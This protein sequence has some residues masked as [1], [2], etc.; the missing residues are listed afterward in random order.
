MRTGL[1]AAAFVR[2]HCGV[3]PVVR[4]VVRALAPTDL[5]R[6]FR[7]LE[8]AFGH[9]PQDEDVPV[10]LALVDP[11][12][13]YG[14]YAGDEL[15]GTAGSFAFPMTVPGGRLDVAG[16]TWVGV[17]PTARRQ[18]VLR[19]FMTGQLADLHAAGTAVAA[20]WASE[21]AIYPRYGY[22][23]AAWHHA[24]SIPRGA[25]FHRQVEPGGLRHV[26]PSAALLGPVYDAVAART[27]G[28][29]ARDD[30]WWALRLHD[31]EHARAGA[32]A[33]QCVVTDGGYALYAVAGV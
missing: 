15:V 30:A 8:Q 1:S 29:P 21:G 13:F 28:W 9:S 10:E 25:R 16:V 23:P 18:G 2:A 6:G 17:A 31:P 4:P 32:T 24:V 11:A 33:L 12:R 20:L 26:E 22:G 27:P 14:A 3:T 5:E 19:A 7:L